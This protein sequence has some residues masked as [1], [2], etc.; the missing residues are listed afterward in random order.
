MTDHYAEAERLL[1]NVGNIADA[2]D[3]AQCL[4]EAQ[5]HAT[6]AFVQ[7]QR[8]TDVKHTNLEAL[9]SE[10]AARG[11]R[12]IPWPPSEAVWTRIAEAGHTQLLDQF[13][14]QVSG[15]LNRDHYKA[16]AY[17]ILDVIGVEAS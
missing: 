16:I 2:A 6:L 4:V 14:P 10:Q 17:A 1:G 3:R 13:G 9:R 15:R 8:R 7:W 5:A 11:V 12:M